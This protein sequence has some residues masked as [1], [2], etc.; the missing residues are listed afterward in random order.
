MKIDKMGGSGGA[1][2]PEGVAP[3]S[4]GRAAR[5]GDGP[6]DRLDLSDAARLRRE[7][8]EAAR[9]LGEVR[10]A[11]VKEVRDAAPREAGASDL[12]RL[13]QA[14]LEFEDDLSR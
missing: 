8:L 13:A 4:R 7:L 11:R 1:G 5:A 3:A 10:E 2:Q 12:R 14:I 6:A 9:N